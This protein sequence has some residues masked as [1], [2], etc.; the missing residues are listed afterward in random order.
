MQR[1]FPSLYS[2]R[3]RTDRTEIQGNR[4]IYSVPTID[5]NIIKTDWFGGSKPTLI[6]KYNLHKRNT[7]AYD[8][9]FNVPNYNIQANL[10]QI[11]TNIP[12]MVLS[13]SNRVRNQLGSNLS[14]DVFNPFINEQYY[15]DLQ[16]LY[17]NK[18]GINSITGGDGSWPNVQ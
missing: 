16:K 7:D 4:G 11:T 6:D 8:N 12:F 9:M 1:M 2:N 18:Y 10:D 13:Q 14:G 15:T 3:L 17:S 5:K